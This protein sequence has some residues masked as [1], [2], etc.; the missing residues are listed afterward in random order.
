MSKEQSAI[1]SK[2]VVKSPIITNNIWIFVLSFLKNIDIIKSLILICE[3][4][5][6]EPRLDF[7]GT[8]ELLH[9]Y[10][11][12]LIKVS[13]LSSSRMAVETSTVY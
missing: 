9:F 1:A 6:N 2:K 10:T 7:F 3:I 13:P 11:S 12:D 4:I 8:W 5:D